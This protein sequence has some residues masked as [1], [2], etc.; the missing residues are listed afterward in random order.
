MSLALRE[1]PSKRPSELRDDDGGRPARRAVVR[2]AWRLFRREWHRQALIL[3]LLTVAVQLGPD[4]SFGTANT[5]ITLPGHDPD[6]TADIA[7]AQS[8]FG[9]IDV[10]TH[11]TVAVPGSVSTIDIRAENPA[12]PYAHVM[13]RL[14]AGRYPTGPDQVAVTSNV[15]KIFDLH[16]VAGRRLGREP[17]EPAGPVRARGPRPSESTCQR[18]HPGRWRPA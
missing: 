11:Q 9:T 1:R 12:G 10:I 4:P 14:D 5:I 16:I 15:A 17:L 13:L 18:V 7:Y 8:R 6:L 3:A 2:W